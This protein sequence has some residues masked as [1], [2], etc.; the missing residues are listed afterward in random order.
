M[1]VTAIHSFNSIVCVN[2]YAP[3][4]GS[5]DEEAVALDNLT[6]GDTYYVRIYNQASIFTGGDFTICVTGG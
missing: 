6:V 5:A 1:Q 3:L 2:D 4:N